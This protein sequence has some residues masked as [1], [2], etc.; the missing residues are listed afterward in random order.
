MS[1]LGAPQESREELTAS[2]YTG[3]EP[4]EK[5]I[6]PFIPAP[7]PS[8]HLAPST[9]ADS[10]RFGCCL[11]STHGWGALTCSPQALLPSSVYS[12]NTPTWLSWKQTNLRRLS[13]CPLPAVTPSVL[14]RFYSPKF[15][16]FSI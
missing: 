14:E 13:L 6:L 7:K 16:A 8:S 15:N 2:I 12:H 1:C 4:V 10:R 5:L 11:P 3:T 9:R